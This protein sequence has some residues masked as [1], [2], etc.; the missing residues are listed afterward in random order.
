M[1]FYQKFYSDQNYKDYIYDRYGP[2]FEVISSVPVK[3]S[4][5]FNKVLFFYMGVNQ[6]SFNSMNWFVK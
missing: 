3:K 5:L 4:D 2:L 6:Y 1:L